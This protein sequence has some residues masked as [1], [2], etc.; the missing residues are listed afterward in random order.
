MIS[1]EESEEIAQKVKF[2]AWKRLAFKDTLRF[3]VSRGVFVSDG[4]KEEE[5]EE[6]KIVVTIQGLFNA[7]CFHLSTIVGAERS[8]GATSQERVL[9]CD[10]HAWNSVLGPDQTFRRLDSSTE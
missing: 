3:V 5:I 1:A 2:I 10:A 8:N 7:I 6:E 9:A 4:R